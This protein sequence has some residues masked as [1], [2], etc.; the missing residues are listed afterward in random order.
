MTALLPTPEAAGLE[1]VD[2]NGLLHQAWRRLHRSEADVPG[3]LV[4]LNALH[5]AL[6]TP[7]VTAASAQAAIDAEKARADRLAKGIVQAEILIDDAIKGIQTAPLSVVTDTIWTADPCPMT[8]VEAL[9][10][11]RAALQQETQP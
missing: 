8:V 5:V 11:A 1:V 2:L 9:Q 10:L 4:V 3:A 7:L 6:E